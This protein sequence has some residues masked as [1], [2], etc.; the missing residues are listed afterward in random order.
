MEARTGRLSVILGIGLL[1]VSAAVATAQ[2]PSI[3][4]TEQLGQPQTATGK[5]VVNATVVSVDGNKVVAKD[6]AGK[7]TEYTIPEGF[8]F[9]FEGRDIG[10]AELK[11]GMT[12]SATVTT[13]TTTT[14]VYVTE[15][16][17]GKVLAVSGAERHRPWAARESRVLEPGRGETEC[18]DHAQRAAGLLERPA[19][20]RHFYGRDRHG[21]GAEG[22][23]P[24]ARSRP[25]SARRPNPLLRPRPRLPPLPPLLPPRMCPS[26]PPRMPPLLPPR[27]FPLRPPRIPR[28]RRPPSMPRPRPKSGARAGETVFDRVLADSAADCDR[29]HRVAAPPPQ[30]LTAT[31]SN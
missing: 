21:C 30:V 7:A 10:V 11:P 31:V 27:M 6:A 22:R 12:V 2:Q 19:P 25:W 18:Q 23:H 8:K 4:R 13:T 15:I 14:P 20:R 28:P 24:S 16:R 26:Q 5:R 1:A 9:Q 29:N 3:T 17:T